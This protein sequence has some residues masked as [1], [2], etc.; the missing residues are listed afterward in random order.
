LQIDLKT[1]NEAEEEMELCDDENESTTA[2]I[3]DDEAILVEDR[4]VENNSE[5]VSTKF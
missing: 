5:K 2:D 3:N 4:K 1:G